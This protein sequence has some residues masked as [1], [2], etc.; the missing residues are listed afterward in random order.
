MQTWRFLS[1]SGSIVLKIWRNID[2]IGHLLSRFILDWLGQILVHRH[3]TASLI[4]FQVLVLLGLKVHYHVLESLIVFLF[5]FFMPSLDALS[6]TAC[7]L[8]SLFTF[9]DDLSTFGSLFLAVVLLTLLIT[10]SNRRLLVFEIVLVFSRS[11]F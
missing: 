7:S 4:G 8:Q 9:I 2:L 5:I 6:G 11:V 3:E 1:F 10:F